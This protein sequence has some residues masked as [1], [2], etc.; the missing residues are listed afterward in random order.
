[1]TQEQQQP[2]PLTDE[3]NKQPVTRLK[4][5]ISPYVDRDGKKRSTLTMVPDQHSGPYV[6]YWQHARRL[7]AERQA[8]QEA[9][10][11]AEQAEAKCERMEKVVSAVRELVGWMASYTMEDFPSGIVSKYYELVEAIQNLNAHPT[12]QAEDQQTPTPP[13]GYEVKKVFDYYVARLRPLYGVIFPDGIH[14]LANRY[15]TEH[16]YSTH[17][18]AVAVCWKHYRRQQQD[19]PQKPTPSDDEPARPEHEVKREVLSKA[20]EALQA[21]FDALRYVWS[22]DEMIGFH[23]AIDYLECHAKDNPHTGLN[24]IAKVEENSR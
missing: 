18:T 3:P 21:D 4:Q 19:T 23:G 11:R 22:H 2:E 1:M 8:C 9:E 13:E 24:R 12:E 14:R 17:A 7:N 15:D 16:C 6:P 10:R 5:D 20:I